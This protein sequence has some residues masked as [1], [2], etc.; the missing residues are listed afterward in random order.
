MV[1]SSWI[2]R[3]SLLS[4]VVNEEIISVRELKWRRSA[5]NKSGIE[6]IASG[7]DEDISNA[8]PLGD[9]V[10]LGHSDIRVA[11]EEVMWRLISDQNRTTLRI[12]VTGK[13]WP[14]SIPTISISGVLA[15]GQAKKD[16]RAIV[17]SVHHI[18]EGIFLVVD[19]TWI[20]SA[21]AICKAT[22]CKDNRLSSDW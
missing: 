18:V 5:F 4:R 1:G 12:L 15:P 20:L 19:H 2:F 21:P 17:G 6:M 8:I 16:G 22:R 14:K 9:I 7:R 10:A 13:Y 3:P 11:P